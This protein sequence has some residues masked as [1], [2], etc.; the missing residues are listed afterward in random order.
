MPAA[1][2][3]LPLLPADAIRTLAKYGNLSALEARQREIN[4]QLKELRSQSAHSWAADRYFAA[5]SRE[6]VHAG[7]GLRVGRCKPALLLAAL[8]L[9]A[10]FL[11]YRMAPDGPPD[12]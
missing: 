8:L 9:A 4:A 7:S 11:R 10:L 1:R 5:S 3:D 6:G 2:F 12:T